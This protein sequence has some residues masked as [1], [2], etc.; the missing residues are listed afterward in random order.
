MLVE[1][2]FDTGEVVLNYAEGPDNGPPLWLIH[3][4][5]GNWRRLQSIFPYLQSRWHIYAT[6][7]RGHG[8]S[9]RTPTHYGLGYYYKDLQAFLDKKITEPAVIIGHSKGGVLSCMRASKNIEKVNALVL[10]DPPLF[11]HRTSMARLAIW[12][13]FHKI[14]LKTGAV[15]EKMRYIEGVTLDTDRGQVKFT[16]VMDSTDAL[17]YALNNVD[18]SILEEKIKSLGDSESAAR[19]NSWYSPEHV[20]HLIECPVLLIQAGKGDTLLDSKVEI[21]KGW[22]KD[23]IQLKFKN[24]DHGLGIT[25]WKPSEAIRPISYLLDSFL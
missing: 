3:G 17:G 5:T 2:S 20:L 19:Y 23:L 10:L 16:D 25:N 21:V 22:V 12:E 13:T 11:F 14:A 8:K 9:G 1:K 7:L 18:P 4:F 24:L 15:Q 6:D